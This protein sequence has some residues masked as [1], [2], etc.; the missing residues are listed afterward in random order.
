VDTFE[1]RLISWED[2]TKNAIFII[3]L[4]HSVSEIYLHICRKYLSFIIWRRFILS[5]DKIYEEL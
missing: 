3:L 5:E 1:V 4:D 2:K